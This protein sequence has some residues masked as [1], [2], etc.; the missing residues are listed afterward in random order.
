VGKIPAVPI[1]IPKNK[2]N[3]GLAAFQP[4]IFITLKLYESKSILFLKHLRGLHMISKIN[5][6]LIK[7]CAPVLMGLKPSAIFTLDCPNCVYHLKQSVSKDFCV[8]ALCLTGCKKILTMLYS[9]VLCEKIVFNR[10]SSFILSSLGYPSKANQDFISRLKVRFAL[11][12]DFPHEVGFLL[13]YPQE[14]VIG[15]I[16]NEGRNYKHCGLWKVYGDVEEHTKC[17]MRYHLSGE[18]LKKYIERGGDVK[19]FSD[20]LIFA[21]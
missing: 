7:H 12:A 1:Q 4:V 21:A 15:F 20:T 6:I 14:D 3:S 5:E 8:E 16:E 11:D 9:P 13:G 19:R 17:C 18:C 2:K 10:K